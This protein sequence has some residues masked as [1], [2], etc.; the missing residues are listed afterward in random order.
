MTLPLIFVRGDAYS[1]GVQHGE[2]LRDRVL[3]N[4]ELYFHRFQ[5]EVKLSRAQTLEMARVIA[6]NIE[7]FEPQYAEAMRGIAA[8]VGREYLEI[9]ALNAR[10]EILYYGYGEQGLVNAG[11]STRDS[12]R[13][14]KT[15]GC[16]VFAVLPEAMATGHLTMGQNWD[17]I[18]GVK[19]ALVRTTHPDGLEHL[20]FTEAGIYG[21]KIG[22][23]SE[24]VGVCI[25]GLVSMDDDWSRAVK[26]TH[27][28]LYEILRSRTFEDA[29]AVVSDDA[30]A[31]STNFMIGAAPDKVVDIETAPN[32]IR[33]LSCNLGTMAHT[34]HFLE[35]DKLGIVEPPSE[36]RPHSYY[37]QDLMTRLLESK[38]PL[39]ISDIQEFLK[40]REDDPDG[41]C[42]YPN[43]DEPEAD[44]TETIAGIIMDLQTREMWVSDGQPDANPFVHYRL[45]VNA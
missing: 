13:T 14:V 32:G 5:Y 34:N 17:Y 31:C 16:T 35:P 7:H 45:E 10:Y 29:V 19:G 18:V 44:R 25:S 43:L 9:A 15:D 24:G 6:G 21:G 40:N 42:R 38:R 12:A 11:L 26:P 41:I 37:R 30:R 4:L 23:N 22:V 8:A 3:H 20:A 1:Q 2:Q 28:R 39:E 27:L 36:R 33:R